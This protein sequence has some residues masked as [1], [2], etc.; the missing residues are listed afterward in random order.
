MN[1]RQLIKRTLEF[2]KPRRIP[3]E[4]W[5]LPWAE[6]NHPQ[7]LKGIQQKYPNDITKPPASL[8]QPLNT[9]GDPFEIGAYVDEWGCK[10]E[11]KQAGIIGEVKEPV[12]K[13]LSRL[14]DVQPPEQCLSVDTEAVNDFCRN[15]DKFVIAACCPRPFER[16]QFLRGTENV[17]M[18][19]A[20]DLDRLK[21]LIAIIHDFY[22][23]ELQ[24]WAKTDVDG[25]MFMDDWG[26]QRSLLIAPRTWRDIFK[27]L[28][29]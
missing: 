15:T 20:M 4:L 8:K 1:S 7:E 10:F 26:M 29:A 5:T 6:N 11:N 3:R 17:M 12:V 9:H 18:D 2:D 27:P 24:I 23:K 22:V 13:D 25:L 16:L 14:E 28:Y 21:E 19:L